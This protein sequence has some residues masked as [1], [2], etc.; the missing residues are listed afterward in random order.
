M[1]KEEAGIPDVNR[2]IRQP[3]ASWS[4]ALDANSLPSKF[5]I[6][7][8]YYYYYYNHLLHQFYTYIYIHTC[9]YICIEFFV[10]LCYLLHSLWIV[11]L[12]D[13][14]D[15]PDSRMRKISK[16]DMALYGMCPMTM[17]ESFR[18]PDIGRFI[19]QPWSSWITALEGNKLSSK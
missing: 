17:N 7:N 18:V 12:E 1:D 16:Q 11:E 14:N 9:I 13:S 8:Y 10:L 5:F 15:I 3:W 2:F 19:R 4:A 6:Y